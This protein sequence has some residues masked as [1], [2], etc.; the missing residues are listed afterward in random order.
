VRDSD[1]QNIRTKLSLLGILIGIALRTFTI[2]LDLN[3]KGL[4]FSFEGLSILHEQ[5]NLNYL[6]DFIPSIVLAIVGNFIGTSFQRY[7]KKNKEAINSLEN[8]K[9]DVFLF[10]EQLRKRDISTE[11]N[12]SQED[13]LGRS[14]INLKNE[15]TDNK[16]ADE[17]RKS[18]DAQRQWT[19]EGL[20]KFGA[21]LRDKSKNI[22]ELSE[23]VTSNLS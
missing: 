17:K 7:Y 9:D 5:N 14:L 16:L 23:N 20:A 3:G 2:L 4:D 6:L 19:S 8:K 1:I 18:E 12:I 11:H 10:V 22:E 21:I 15:L 13:E